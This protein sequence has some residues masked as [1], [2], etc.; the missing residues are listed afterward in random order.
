MFY[1]F[2]NNFQ[3]ILILFDTLEKNYLN[4]KSLNSI[5]ELFCNQF[6][7]N[8]YVENQEN[9]E[10][11]IFF[12]T[13]FF[14]EIGKDELLDGFGILDNNI[15]GKILNVFLKKQE[16]KSCFSVILRDV[17]VNIDLVSDQFLELELTRI[18]EYVRLKKEKSSSKEFRFSS[19][20]LTNVIFSIDY[21]NLTRKLK[22]STLARKNTNVE[23]EKEV[24]KEQVGSPFENHSNNSSKKKYDNN[25]ET[26]SM[27]DDSI[28]IQFCIK[29]GPIIDTRKTMINN[30]QNNDFYLEEVDEPFSDKD[31][32]FEEQEEDDEINLDYKIMLDKEEL[33]KRGK[34]IDNKEFKYFYYKQLERIKDDTTI[35]TNKKLYF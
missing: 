1:C 2:R 13:L 12:Y 3:N 32:Y 28:N 18:D 35:F 22:K 6:F 16:F 19:S 21:N 25:S 11:L 10:L 34:D 23:F 17:M 27:I 7:D 29:D 31:Y 5:L 14:R 4:S 33:F 8:L 26:S 20:N 30:G 9:E 24:K 15:L